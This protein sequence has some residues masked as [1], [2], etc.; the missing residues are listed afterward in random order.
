MDCSELRSL[1]HEE[2]L[3]TNLNKTI[4]FDKPTDFSL[5]VG[6][7]LYQLLRRLHLSALQQEIDSSEFCKGEQKVREAIYEERG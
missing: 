5:V 3:L 2:V 7:P 6:G 4:N 1:Y